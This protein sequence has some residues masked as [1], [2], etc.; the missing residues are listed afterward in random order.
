MTSIL[1][2]TV[3]AVEASG[4]TFDGIVCGTVGNF[5]VVSEYND[6]GAVRW[7]A[8]GDPTD[9]PTPNTNDARS[10]QAGR[11]HLNPKLGVVTGIAGN[12]FFGYV[13][14]EWGITK[15]TYV[16]GDIVFTFDTFSEGVGCYRYNR[17]AQVQDL[18][19]FESQFGYHLLKDGQVANIGEGL[20]DTTY[21]PVTQSQQRNVAVNP[22]ISTFFFEGQNLAYNYHTQQWSEQ[23]A[24]LGRTYYS[25]DSEADLVGQIVFSGTSVDDQTSSGGASTEATFETAERDLNQGGRAEITGVRPIVNGGTV[26]VFVGVRNDLDDSVVY[27]TGS[28]VNSRTGMSH[29]K[30]AANKA[31]GRYQRLRFLVN[32]A[33]ET[34]LGADVEFVPSGQ[35]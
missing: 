1:E 3:Y 32:G 20:V 26:S 7:C 9:W 31:E 23:N 21:P 15:M 17:F 14:Q 6:P 29:F 5:M 30:S 2:G 4:I 34:T 13:F 28:S 22:A 8:I 25:V 18:V 11:E 12:D 10:K 24:L 16:G 33:N 35:V 19:A 27:A